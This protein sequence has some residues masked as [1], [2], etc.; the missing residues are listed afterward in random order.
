MFYVP[1][2]YQIAARLPE[3][4][5]RDLFS[6]LRSDST[7][8]SRTLVFNLHFCFGGVESRIVHLE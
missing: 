1:P 4:L 7:V 3:I 8:S 6:R 5:F 2:E